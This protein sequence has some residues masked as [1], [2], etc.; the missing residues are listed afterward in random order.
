M[1]YSAVITGASGGIGKALCQ[2]FQNAGYKVIGLD[3]P[4]ANFPTSCHEIISCDLE[5]FSCDPDYRNEVIKKIKLYFAENPL[6]VLVN[7]AAIQVIKSTDE[8]AYEDW[9][10]TLSVNLIAPFLL[11]KAFLKYL[12]HAN[13]SVINIAS[14]HAKVTKPGFVCYST[15]KSA[16]VGLTRSLAVDL[17]N[18]IRVN[19]ISPAAVS[20][21]MLLAGFEEKGD[22]LE[23]LSRMHP[24]GRIASPFEIAQAAVF[25]A[26]DRASFIT[27]TVLEVD[28]GINARLHDP[29]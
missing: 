12:T 27:G 7:N 8:I 3:K 2:E 22:L 26:S 11:V 17:G 14:I 25:L 9:D 13:G 1:V 19:A 4:Q 28:G 18:K 29:N 23:D 20:T 16:L 10:R 5:I 21:P 24:I 6:Q 15:S